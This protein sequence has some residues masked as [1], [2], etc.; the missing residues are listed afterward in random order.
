[1]GSMPAG[2]R[3][4]RC[5]TR[6]A[7]DNSGG[8]CGRCERASR[9][10]LIAPP[11]VPAEFWQ[12][13]QLRDAFAQQHMGRVARA[14]RLHPYHQ[15]VYGPSGIPQGLLGQWL[16]LSQPQVSRIETGPPIR[17]LDTLAY[18]AR[19][20]RTP[21]ELLWFRLPAE[22]RQ[23]TTTAP[24]ARHLTAPASSS[25]LEP[26]TETKTEWAP[27]VL[28]PLQDSG[29]LVVS[30]GQELAAD[31][32]L[33]AGV[34]LTKEFSTLLDLNYLAFLSSAAEAVPAEWGDQL[35][36]HLTKFLHGW[37]DRM[38]R[39][40]L[41]QLLGWAA[42]TV[43]ASPVVG[44]LEAEE[45]KRLARAIVSPSRVDEQV[46]DHLDATLRHCQLQED[47]LGSRAVLPTLLGQRNLVRDLLTECPDN[48]RGRLLST[49]SNMSTSIGYYFFEL[50]DVNRS[51]RYYEQARAAA[52][53]AG[54]PEL[55]IYALC[56]WSYT[57]SWQGQ[58]AANG[59]D[60]AAVA[61]S[62]VSK[63][64]D[65]L[66]R[67]GAAQRA[68]TAYAF[69]GQDKACMV[70]LERAQDSLAS[71]RQVSAE[72]PAYFWNKGYLTSH[73]SE[74]LLRL[75]KPQEAVAS[76]SAGLMLYDKSFVDGYAVCT[77]HLGNAHLQSGEIDEAAR[78]IGSAASLAARTRSARLVKELRTTRARM[79]PWQDSQA[80]K[81]LDEQLA[82][83][84]FG[85]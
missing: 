77:L 39:R 51:R 66:M 41:L 47:A 50:N 25:A 52:H 48:L 10:K 79:Q 3:Y 63:T 7:A 13:E 69:D 36:E 61:Q 75:G 28:H 53:D 72:S 14:Y 29:Q 37:V 76:A 26:P 27:T 71:A 9:D 55:S 67:V 2:K 31:I 43:A 70:E 35:Y 85:A 74:C 24:V 11:E 40:E 49:Y 12:T 4:C 34:E 15:P 65:P 6:L 23:R 45:Q 18:W 8:Q 82:G 38:N 60:L 20:L 46:I 62:L 42:S 1:M 22:K 58:A 32:M 17:N 16:G 57:E 33:P 84:G 44:S 64:E 78:V 81:E 73:R 59:I 68:A 21:P 30:S 19:T 5:G 80:I 54:S 83:I 56:E